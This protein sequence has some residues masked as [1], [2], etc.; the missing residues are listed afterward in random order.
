MG[1]EMHGVVVWVVA[2]AIQEEMC[3][4]PVILGF[5]AVDRAHA[6]PDVFM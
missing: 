2:V 6:G 4:S 1:G 5:S 3:C